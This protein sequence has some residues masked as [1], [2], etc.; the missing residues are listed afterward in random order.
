MRRIVP[1][2]LICSL[3]FLSAMAPPAQ[4]AAA[5]AQPAAPAGKPA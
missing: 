1:L 4:A 5:G 2:L 3:L